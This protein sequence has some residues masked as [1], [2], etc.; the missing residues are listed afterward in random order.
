MTSTSDSVK[1]FLAEDSGLIRARLQDALGAADIDVIGQAGTP[2][3]CIS[4]ILDARPDVVVLDIQL[5]GGSGLEVLKAVR[6]A[7]PEVAFIVF[8]SHAAPVFR[9]RYLQEGAVEFLDK[10]TDF[11]QLIPAVASAGRRPVH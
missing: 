4:G 8:S 3:A 10:S 5:E 7:E 6:S 2:Q 9:K 11:E 1:A